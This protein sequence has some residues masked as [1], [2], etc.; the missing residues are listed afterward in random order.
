MD[1]YSPKSETMENCDS[2]PPDSEVWNAR[3]ELL[4]GKDVIDRLSRAKILIVGV[5]GVGSF[6]AEFLTRAGVGTLVLV[7]RDIVSPSNRNRQIQATIET[8]GMPKAEVLSRRLRSINPELNVKSL[9]MH[10]DEGNEDSIFSH[11]PFDFAVD[12]IDTL[13]PKTIFLRECVRRNIPV[14]SSMGS[15]GKLDPAQVKIV[16]IEETNHCKLA[17]NV[18]KRLHRMGIRGGIAAVFSPEPVDRARLIRENMDGKAS[19]GG[20]I[21]YMPAIFGA[22]LASIAIRFFCKN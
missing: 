15:A 16:D 11:G 18:R 19:V 20:T 5:G 7:D 6:A 12:A 21:S 8:E 22:N 2:T 14:A 10:F 4:L 9:V 17:Y 1:N 13:H 3:T